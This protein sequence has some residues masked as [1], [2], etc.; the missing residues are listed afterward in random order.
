M[1]KVKQTKEYKILKKR[2][3]RYAVRTL[4]GKWVNGEDKVKVLLSEKLIKISPKKAEVSAES[5]EA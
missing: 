2:N 4:K 3:G 5:T 1:E